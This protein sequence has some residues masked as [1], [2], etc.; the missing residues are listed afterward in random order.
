[1]LPAAAAGPSKGHH[2]Q[3]S[4]GG[5]LRQRAQ[6]RPLYSVS[7][8]FFFPFHLDGEAIKHQGLQRGRGCRGRG[9]RDRG[10]WSLVCHQGMEG[11]CLTRPAP[12]SGCSAWDSGTLQGQK[13]LTCPGRAR[14]ATS[15][16]QHRARVP[17]GSSPVPPLPLPSSWS[18]A[19]QPAAPATYRGS[20]PHRGVPALGGLR[21]LPV[22]GLGGPKP[23]LPSRRG[24]ERERR[25][26][27]LPTRT[28]PSCLSLPGQRPRP[29]TPPPPTSRGSTRKH[30]LHADP[31]RPPPPS[32]EAQFQPRARGG[33][34]GSAEERTTHKRGRPGPQP[35]ASSP[36][37]AACT[38]PPLHEHPRPQTRAMPTSKMA[39][40]EAPPYCLAPCRAIG[41]RAE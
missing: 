20:G 39:A 28:A 40:P 32:P 4:Q 10:A 1:M 31:A 13:Q 34:R 38:S 12:Q 22:H 29:E 27:W 33:R 23:S 21:L 26:C 16:S 41:Q 17:L 2:C 37:G 36:R 19:W 9:C 25:K 6:P 14:S 8:F 18:S 3:N 15:G 5:R 35:L 24:G 11:S 30:T 7:T